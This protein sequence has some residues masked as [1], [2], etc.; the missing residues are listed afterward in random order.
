MIDR[1]KSETLPWLLRIK[2][3]LRQVN[4]VFRVSLLEFFHRK[5]TWIFFAAS[6]GMVLLS[7]LLGHLS[8]DEQVRIFIHLGFFSIMASSLA[9]SVTL[10]ATA[11]PSEIERQTLMMTLVR[12]IS[13][14]SWILG[15]WIA[16]SALNWF[17]VFLLGTVQWL[18]LLL[19]LDSSKLIFERFLLSV[20]SIAIEAQIIFGFTFAISVLVRPALA[21][22]G[23]LLLFIVA[24]WQEDLNFFAKKTHSD[25]FEFFSRVFE[26]TVPAIEKMN[27]RSVAFVTGEVPLSENFFLLLAILWIWVL[28]Y[29]LLSVILFQR[30]DLV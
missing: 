28:V 22:L 2:L 1:N 12:P 20:F 19:Y 26:W 21:V 15:K 10:A 18:I 5:I 3:G 11:L 23:G 7:L 16:I 24:H 8:L 13:R 14:R 17:F 9:L 29:L 25:F 6:F 27:F 4:A 30:R